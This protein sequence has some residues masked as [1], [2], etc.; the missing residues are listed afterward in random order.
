MAAGESRK[1]E[2]RTWAVTNMQQDYLIKRVEDGYVHRVIDT[3]NTNSWVQGL[4]RG[5]ENWTEPAI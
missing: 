4:P 5:L 1:F 3:N 2:G